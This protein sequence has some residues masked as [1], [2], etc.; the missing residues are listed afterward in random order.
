MLYE[1]ITRVEGVE[2]D[3]QGV[4][5]ERAEAFVEEQRVDRGLVADQIGEGEG[6]CQADQETFAAGQGAGVAGDIALP[7]VDDV[8]FE[9][10]AALAAQ[11]VAA[12]QAGQ[13]AV[14]EVQQVVEGEALGEL[15]ELVA[16]G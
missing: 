14:G 8:E 13:V 6:E 5:V 3:F 10:A 2:G 7:A 11:Q 9:F 16:P 1:V 15:A 12:V 4:G